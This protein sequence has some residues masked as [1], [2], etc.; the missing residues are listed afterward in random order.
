MPDKVSAIPNG[1]VASPVSVSIT[2]SPI[3]AVDGKIPL[4]TSLTALTFTANPVNG[5]TNPTYQ[6]KKNGVNIIGATGST[7]TG[8]AQELLQIK[9]VMTSNMPNVTGNPAESNKITVVRPISAGVSITSN[10]SPAVAG[11]VTFTATPV[12]GGGL[13]TYQWKKNGTAI[14][15]ATSSTY[16]GTVAEGDVI[17]VDMHSIMIIMTTEA[18]SNA[19]TITSSTPTNTVP[20]APTNLQLARVLNNDGIT[21]NLNKVNLTWT[22]PTNNGG[23]PITSYKIDYR[24][25]GAI[26][27]TT[28]TSTTT[29]KTIDVTAGTG[30]D[31]V[32]NAVNAIGTGDN[33]AM[34]T[35][36]SKITGVT[37]TP[38]GAGK[39]LVSWIT[40]NNGGSPIL[41][42]RLRYKP[43]DVTP[44][45][46]SWGTLKI[47]S[48]PNA[49]S[50]ELTGL[51]TGKSYQVRIRAINGIFGPW[52]DDTTAVQVSSIPSQSLI[53]GAVGGYDSLANASQNTDYI[54]KDAFSTD[55][56]QGK[57]HN[58]VK[59]LQS[60]LNSKGYTVVPT[61]KE[62]T[63]FGNATKQALIKFQ[64]D[65]NITPA[66]G[67]LGIKT[68]T[69]IN[70]MINGSM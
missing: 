6:W 43:I 50:T 24:I 32:V 25:K 29:T 61:G 22:A 12:N 59:Q 18:T 11:T 7:Y 14:S 54:F 45:P 42:Y 36:P 60:F 44:L 28:T 69:L 70:E 34:V 41:E 9:V 10:P 67:N 38:S 15:G 1:A 4:P 3:S 56:S 39:L 64:Q 46:N 49:T 65:N 62:T 33:G 19:M 16:T 53:G 51:T 63:Y 23:S 26:N 66:S 8:I 5:G 40:P 48:D 30:Y 58:D 31:F 17:T 52:S 47:I 57:K 68:R 35:S 20:G 21:Y 13:P 55:I 27:W 37:V 2:S